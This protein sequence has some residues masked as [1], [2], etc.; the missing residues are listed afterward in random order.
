MYNN[1]TK[2][3]YKDFISST[4]NIYTV[5]MIDFIIV[6]FNF[7][8]LKLKNDPLLISG[9]GFSLSYL[10]FSMCF[11]Y[12]FSEFLGIYLSKSLGK[13]KYKDSTILIFKTF[14]V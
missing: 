12:G 13:K 10:Y 6:S 9:F 8:I 5:M 3:P 14:L 2:Y 11:L 4:W 7:L 1:L